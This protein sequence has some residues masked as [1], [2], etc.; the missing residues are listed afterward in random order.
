MAHHIDL[1]Q[2][3]AAIES[4]GDMGFCLTCGAEA[5]SVEPDARGYPCESC[6][7]HQVYGAEELMLAAEG[8]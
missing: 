6:G 1:E 5:H 4:D 7:A 2:I 8:I 3:L